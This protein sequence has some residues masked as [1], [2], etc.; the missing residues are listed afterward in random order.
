MD[1]KTY[2]VT[3]SKWE[4]LKRVGVDNMSSRQLWEYYDAGLAL[5]KHE[6]DCIV[7]MQNYV[8][9][10]PDVDGHRN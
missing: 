5:V 9:D 10:F 8:E 7:R 3:K 4:W 2:L 6:T 1:A